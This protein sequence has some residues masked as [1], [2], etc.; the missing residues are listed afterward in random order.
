MARERAGKHTRDPPRSAS[1]LAGAEDG[2]GFGAEGA[3]CAAIHDLW[4]QFTCAVFT[5]PCQAEK[6]IV[7]ETQP[8]ARQAATVRGRLWVCA[9]V[10]GVTCSGDSHDR[11]LR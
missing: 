10:P 6:P 11:R 4:S 5:T 1:M 8:G 7:L 2:P 3:S 9:D